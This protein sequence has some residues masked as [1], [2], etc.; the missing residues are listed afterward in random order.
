[1]TDLSFVCSRL[2]A[3]KRLIAKALANETGAFF[4]HINGPEIMSKLA[5]E[6]ESSL[7]KVF[8][9]AER[10]APAII[11][12]D[13]ID[14]IAPKWEK[15]QVPPT[16][17]SHVLTRC[18]A[19]STSVSAARCPSYPDTSLGPLKSK[20]NICKQ[21]TSVLL[22]CAM[23]PAEALLQVQSVFERRIMSQLLTLM[24]SLKLH[25]HVIVIGATDRPNRCAACHASTY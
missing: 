20:P 13:E 1:M 11:F 8:E 4:L 24:D 2:S 15:T 16:L 23:A 17:P 3:G 12:I 9:E 18:V 19:D 22:A 6:S 10:N 21:Y 25:A 7:R 14:F 5:G